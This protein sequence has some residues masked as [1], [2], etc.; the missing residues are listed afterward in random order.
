MVECLG[1]FLLISPSLWKGLK[2][3]GAQ[4]VRYALTL[5]KSEGTFLKQLFK[6]IHMAQL[7]SFLTENRVK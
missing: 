2:L 6:N 1:I 3:L 5:K 7:S 4:R